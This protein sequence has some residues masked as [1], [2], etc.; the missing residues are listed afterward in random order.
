MADPA[1]AWGIARSL[2]IYYGRPWLV[3]AQS[4]LYR[5]FI[6]PGDLAFDIG[7][8]VGNRTR[9][10]RRLGARVVAL[11]PQPALAALLRRQFDADPAVTVRAAALGARPG[12][13]T[14]LASRRTPTVSTLSPGWVERMRNTPGFA[15]VTWQ[16][17]HEVA[18]TTLDALIAEHG[19]PQ[20]CKIDVEGYEARILRGLSQPIPL[21]SFEY[22]PAAFDIACEAMDLVSALGSYRFNLTIGER[23]QWRWP[24]WQEAAVVERW[25][26]ERRPEDRSG[27]IYGRLEGSTL[28]RLGL[29]STPPRPEIQANPRALG[30]FGICGSARFVRDA[31]PTRQTKS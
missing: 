26:R 25:L 28:E 4:R 20:F 3:R 11:E 2:L 16:D 12:T 7:A 24:A 23:R 22:V 15:R 17:R 29:V 1:T 30:S 27:D 5:S 13:A 14:L 9:A 31:T 6:G 18:V 10:L 21:L 8:H 19:L